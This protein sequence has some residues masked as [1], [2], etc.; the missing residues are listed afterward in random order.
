MSDDEVETVV[1]E[2]RRGL[3][4]EMAS[5]L[6]YEVRTADEHHSTEQYMDE[7]AGVL[8]DALEADSVSPPSPQLLSDAAEAL[9]EE[10]Y[11]ID[12]AVEGESNVAAKYREYADE[13]RG[14][15]PEGDDE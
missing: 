8:D 4:D 9:S 3:V 13:L 14:C 7:F 11:R 15:L 2:T 10:A 6:S 5:I 12:E 1:I